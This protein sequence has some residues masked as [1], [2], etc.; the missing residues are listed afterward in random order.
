MENMG[1]DHRLPAASVLMPG[2]LLERRVQ[3]HCNEAGRTMKKDVQVRVV[4]R[5]PVPNGAASFFVSKKIMRSVVYTL[6]VIY[7][8]VCLSAPRQQAL[9][10]KI[11]SFNI[12]KL[13]DTKMG[14][15]RVVSALVE[16][17]A[18]YDLVAV[19]E[20]TD[21]DGD[22]F[23]RLMSKLN[24]FSASN[25]DYVI[26]DRVGRTTAKEQ[27]A[28]VYRPDKVTISDMWVYDD[29]NRDVFE[30]E[31]YVATVTAVDSKIP[32]FTLVTIHTKPVDAVMEVDAL[33]AVADSIRGSPRAA[34]NVMILGDYNAD[35]SYVSN[36]DWPSISLRQRP[37][38]RWWILDDQDTTVRESTH[39]AYDRIVTVGPDF[40]DL[41]NPSSVIIRDFTT[42][43]DFSGDFTPLNVSDH[44]P[45]ELRLE[46]V[47]KTGDFIE[48]KIYAAVKNSSVRRENIDALLGVERELSG[49]GRLEQQLDSNGNLVAVIFVS[50]PIESTTDRKQIILRLT[51]LAP[52]IVSPKA[53]NSLEKK[54]SKL[55][56]Q[57]QREISTGIQQSHSQILSIRCSPK[58]KKESFW[59]CGIFI[60]A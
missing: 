24:E 22:A 23:P 38:F 6:A 9:S 21:V 15:P 5:Q 32:R 49:I 27:Y 39:C 13:G 41:I 26:S 40:E 51:Q 1:F 4:A 46:P 17:L 59:M 18:D 42:E 31:P 10:L 45:I 37:E 28:Y 36:N 50:R 57:G 33:A 34:Q 48:P 8:F 3:R 16:I 47:A 30:R 19:Q 56:K 55:K 53:V 60:S 20:I 52:Y 12:E 44:F 25:Y 58:P 14:R 29:T 43:F 11:A 7:S 54:F 35:C 2:Q